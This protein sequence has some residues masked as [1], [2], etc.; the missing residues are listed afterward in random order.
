[1]KY[2]A[3]GIAGLPA[4]L[5]TVELS[6][7]CPTCGKKTTLSSAASGSATLSCT[8]CAYRAEFPELNADVIAR[9]I[10]EHAA[11]MKSGSAT[12]NS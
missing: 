4:I 11:S 3:T 7:V 8:A 9:A 10:L 2:T 12:A 1:M 5:W 6:A